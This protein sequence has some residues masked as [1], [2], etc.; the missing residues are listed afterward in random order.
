MDSADP[1][2]VLEGW[3]YNVIGRIGGEGRPVYKCLNRDTNL[4][5]SVKVFSILEEQ[6][7][8]IPGSIIREI[9]LL[10]ELKH[11]NIVR[12]L[13]VLNKGYDIFL[14]FERPEIDLD[15][16]IKN[17][18][19]PKDALLVKK[20]LHQMLSAIAYLHSHNVLHRDLKPQNVL[21]NLTDETVKLSNIGSAQD[22]E[23]GTLCYSYNAPEILF[24][25]AEYSKA[26]DMWS[27][28]CIFAE[29]IIGRSL[30]PA[31]KELQA[32]DQII[33][34]LGS[35]SEESWPGITSLFDF[36]NLSHPSTRPKDLALEFPTLA[37]ACVDLLS[38]ML[39]LYPNGRIPAK[40]AL[41]HEFF[42]DI[43]K[44]Q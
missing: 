39:C 43:E 19:I 15:E 4:V 29:M 1:S 28:G 26:S 23:V 41:K 36:M 8:G 42:N 17:Q 6:N 22:H 40:E 11:P 2:E 25:A 38:K 31:T 35:P 27:V 18:T 12:L 20:F 14:V 9:S 13:K 34:L 44:V 32:F 5:V 30:F 33:N 3:N 21:V 37:P 24:G 7:E 16:F 10:K